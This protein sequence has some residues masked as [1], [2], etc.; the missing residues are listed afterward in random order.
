MRKKGAQL[1][2]G[3]LLLVVSSA[4]AQTGQCL[5]PT[6]RCTELVRI[7]DAGRLLVYRNRP[8][9]VRDS[10][11]THIVLV[12]HGAERDAA[13][14]FRIGSAAAVLSGRI[15]STL[16]V[17]PRFAASVG[18]AC[19]DDIADDE[20]NWQCD[21]TL[22]DWRSGGSAQSRPI[23]SFAAL[24]VL[25]MQLQ[26]PTLFPNLRSVV[27]A[28]HSAGGQFVTNYQMTNRAHEALR[29]RPVYVTANASVYAYPDADRP[30]ATD[31][32]ACP[33]YAEWP[34]G[35][36]GRKGYVAEGTSE[37]FLR[38]AVER[39]VTFLVGES[40][41][42]P[43]SEGFYGSCSARA[44]G[45]TRRDRGVA[46]AQHMSERHKATHAA[47]VVPGCAHNER[48]MFLSQQGVQALFPKDR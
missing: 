13:T 23:S 39:P 31:A 36:S 48:C 6:S 47:I 18:K 9:T 43:L 4:E 10:D 30:V 20:L 40:D 26:Q 21:V 44:Q 8:L 37:Q 33:S 3:L 41:T 7:P 14:S 15:E 28:G 1:F 17:A 12:I 16:V 38:R 11:V 45:S 42:Q 5:T 19:T 35:A 24:D 34:F 27:V 25:L 46:F 32:A 2:V 29:I 22:G